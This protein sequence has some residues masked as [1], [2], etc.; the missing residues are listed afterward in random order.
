MP[1]DRGRAPPLNEAAPVAPASAPRPN[2]ISSKID[3]T[4]ARPLGQRLPRPSAA[5]LR[6]GFD[7]LAPRWAR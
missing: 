3:G 7:L 6:A 4:P 2:S 5:K 1:P